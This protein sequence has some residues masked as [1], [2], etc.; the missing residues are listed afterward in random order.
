ML[1]L[2]AGGEGQQ[3]VLRLQVAVDD[4]AR[5][6]RRHRRGEL[7]HQAPRLRELGVSAH[8]HWFLGL[9]S[10]LKTDTR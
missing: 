5:P 2:R 4:A 3:E 8:I 1:D 10:I 7:A 6:Q 9:V